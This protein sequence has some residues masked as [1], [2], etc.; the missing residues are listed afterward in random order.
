MLLSSPTHHDACKLI[1]QNFSVTI[2]IHFSYQ[3]IG[4][5]LAKLL[6]QA[7]ENMPQ[8]KKSENFVLG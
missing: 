1:A 3:L 6:S 5:L 8:L 4:L 2:N 7:C